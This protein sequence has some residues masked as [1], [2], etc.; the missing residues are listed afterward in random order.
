MAI[1]PGNPADADP[2]HAKAKEVFNRKIYP[3]ASTIFR[4]GEPG[5]NAYM[6]L[7]GRV[8]AALASSCARVCNCC[9]T[10]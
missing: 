7:L 9:Q 1:K 6:I 2:R 3:P 4:Q 8:S 5:L 10:A